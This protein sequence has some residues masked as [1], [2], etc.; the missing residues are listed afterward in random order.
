MGLT[1]ERPEEYVHCLLTTLKT[2]MLHP[3]I[4]KLP[5]DLR[6]SLYLFRNLHAA[7]GVANVNFHDTRRDSSYATLDV[8]ADPQHPALV[9]LRIQG[10]RS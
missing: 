3:V 6:T 9:L 5:F 8:G 4:E 1:G 10:N 2:A 7:L